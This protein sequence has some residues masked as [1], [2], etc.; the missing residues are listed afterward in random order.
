MFI[1]RQR[2]GVTA[3]IKKQLKRRQAIE[4]HISHMKMEGKLGRCRLHGMHG[5]QI[6]AIM[7]AAGYNLRLILNHL[8][9]IFGQILYQL[10]CQKFM[11][12]FLPEKNKWTIFEI[13]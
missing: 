8:R 13:A 12:K 11:Q 3:V 1:S 9:I 6:N 2:K 4:P 7:V 5:D 10:I